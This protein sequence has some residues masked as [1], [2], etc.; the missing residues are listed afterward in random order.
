M[1]D[2]KEYFRKNNEIEE[3]IYIGKVFKN[4]QTDAIELKN[5]NTKKEPG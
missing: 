5:E 1:Y 2:I 3:L 4:S